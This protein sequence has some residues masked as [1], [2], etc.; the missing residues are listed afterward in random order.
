MQNHVQCRAIVLLTSIALLTSVA[1][2]AAAP[3]ATGPA[4]LSGIWIADPPLDWVDPAKDEIPLT[5]EYALKLKAWRAAADSGHPVAD[6]V[7][8]CEAFGMPR[9]MSFGATE[10]LQTPRQLTMISEIL[11]EVRRVFLDGRHIP[12]D[13][14]LSY[15]GYSTG[16]WD[17]T[18][19]V[20]STTGLQANTL[21]QYGIP[22]SAELRITER[23]RL[24]GRNRLE[25][26]VT[27]I[28]PKVYTRDWTVTRTYTRAPADFEIQ[29]YICNTN[30]AAKQ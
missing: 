19:L 26:R 7:A 18:T 9:I 5:A 17:K 27:L 28:D 13:Y 25:D 2:Y 20:V 22:H 1:T 10:F 24:L 23:I 8:R 21:D 4:D 12:A 3:L 30:N 14:D 6:S 29:E 16:H 11:H 15:G